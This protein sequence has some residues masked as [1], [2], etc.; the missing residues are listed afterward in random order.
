M[1]HFIFDSCYIG[2][3]AQTQ[4]LKARPG[5]GQIDCS[6]KKQQHHYHR[7]H[8]HHYHH[9]HHHHQTTKSQS[10]S[11]GDRP[12]VLMNSCRDTD[13]SSYGFLMVC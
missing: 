5:H 8:Y 9:H 6:N 7:Y 10:N 4:G 3:V 13:D 11:K 2:E 1:E 12:I